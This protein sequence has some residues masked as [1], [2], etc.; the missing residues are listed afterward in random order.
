MPMR[1]AL[2]R[3]TALAASAVCLA[4][5]AT[6]C[7]G[8]D[9]D[10]GSDKGGDGAKADKKAAARPAVKA[11][12]AAELEKLALAEGDVKDHEIRKVGAG[13]APDSGGITVDKADC[14]PLAHAMMGVQVGEPAATARRGVSQKAKKPAEP[15][16]DELAE[17][18]EEE[19]EEAFTA[20]LDMTMT[21]VSLSS[22]DGAGAER[23]LADL[24]TAATDCGG[25]FTSTAPEDKRKVT[26]IT[27]EKV[28]GGEESAAWTLTTDMEGDVVPVKLVVVRQGGTLAS[29]VS[30]NL[31]SAGG[32]KDYPL[33]TAVI[34]AQL[35]KLG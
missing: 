30:F 28:T 1:P 33:P 25:G 5:L 16:L 22:Y 11:K 2:V 18:T 9:P 32:K 10:G 29:F 17:M 6:A 26:G 24:R 3:R 12:T 19:I 4:L 31:A 8:S 23:T 14:E 20:A 35:A 34:D 21:M 13:E 7:G 27:G 15:S